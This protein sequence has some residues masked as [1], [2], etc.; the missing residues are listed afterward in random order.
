MPNKKK[1]VELVNFPRCHTLISFGDHYLLACGLRLTTS[2]C[3]NTHH[4]VIRK[5]SQHSGNQNKHCCAIHKVPQHFGSQKEHCCVIRKVSQHFGKKMDV[6]MESV[7]FREIS[8][9]K[10]PKTQKW[11]GGELIK[12]GV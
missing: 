5:V 9:R 8:E 3:V 2:K 6:V 10:Q 7:K 11:G 12:I 1:K 4:C